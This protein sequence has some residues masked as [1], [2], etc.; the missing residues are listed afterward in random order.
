MQFNFNHLGNRLCK[1]VDSKLKTEN[2][3]EIYVYD[4]H[5]KCCI[6]C[7]DNCTIKKHCCGECSKFIYHKKHLKSDVSEELNELKH[8]LDSDEEEDI[9]D[10]LKGN[11]IKPDHI[12]LRSG[13]LQLVPTNND[14]NLDTILCVGK[15]GSG[16]SFFI[17]QYLLEFK[18]YYPKYRI[19]LFSQKKE[20]KHLDDLI[21][22]RIPLEKIADANFEP[23]D[24]KETLVIFDDIDAIDDK[25]VN[26]A[27]YEL[28]SKILEV[29]RSY[30]IASIITFHLATDREKTKRILNRC[31]HFVCFKKSYGK[32]TQYALE[33]Y[34]NFTPKQIKKMLTIDTNYYCIIRETPQIVLCR[35][36]I[37]FQ[38]HLNEH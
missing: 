34:I 38:D 1:V 29:G 27:T 36:E 2:G 24:F 31:T 13:R 30:K 19:Y 12:K 20:D 5:F 25:A 16:K 4:K 28:L 9:G 22:K 33:N 10:G 26:K 32:N 37:F 21:T 15:A 35:D 11:N 7:N 3:V 6:Y 17:G 8:L 18:A 23:D 14:N